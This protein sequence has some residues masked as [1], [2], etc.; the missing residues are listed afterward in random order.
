MRTD[1]APYDVAVIGAGPAGSVCAY[2]A[3]TSCEQMRVALIDQDNFPRN[4]PCGDAVRDDA[5]SVLTELNLGALFEGRSKIRHLQPTFPSKF[6]YLGKLFELNKHSYYIIEREALDYYLYKAALRRRASD[7]SGH[8]LVDAEFDESGKSWK[9]IL[10]KRS[11]KTVKI[12]CKTLVGADGAGSK[13][14]RLVELEPQEDEHISLGIRAYAQVDCPGKTIMRFDYLESLIPGYGWT[15]P[16]TEGKVNIGIIIGKPDFKRTGRCLESYLDEYVLYLRS[17]G[18]EVNNLENIKA[19]PLPLRSRPVP[20]VP[21]RQ[22]ALI[23]DAA[24]MIDPLSGEG[25]HYGVWAGRTL[26]HIIGQ[27]MKQDN[28]QNLEDGLQSYAEAYTQQFGK[29]MEFSES[30]R[31]GARFYKFFT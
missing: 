27:C 2:S 14:R 20:L 3:L 24:A 7:Y 5:V 9:L 22:V 31:V 10:T 4:K 19:H 16:L 26:G 13:I 6:S 17:E 11:G 25:I 30:L 28:G 1:T 29:I 21:K 12:N 18:V 8:R 15:F 23:G